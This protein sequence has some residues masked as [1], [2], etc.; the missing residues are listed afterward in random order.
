MAKA[1]EGSG[2]WQA[3]DGRWYPPPAPPGA[4]TAPVS[5]AA[6]LAYPPAQNPFGAPAGPAGTYPSQ[7]YQHYQYGPQQQAT[8]TY[9]PATSGP[10]WGVVGAGVVLI[11]VG[12]AISIGT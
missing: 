9:R 6:P 2:Y 3:S 5:P 7:P 1:Q 10:S 12:L 8:P 4:V 11:I